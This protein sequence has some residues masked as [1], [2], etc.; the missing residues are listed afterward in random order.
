MTGN[1]CK[2]AVW[3]AS[4]MRRKGIKMNNPKRATDEVIKYVYGYSHSHLKGKS[5]KTEL[6][7]SRQVGMTLMLMTGVTS[8]QAGKHYDKDHSTA[9]HSRNVII[10]YLE[11]RHPLQV[12][13]SI[14]Q[15][16]WAMKYF[17]PHTDLSILPE[18]WNHENK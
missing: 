4:E 13:E 9:L 18:N 6:V 11:T 5:R 17:N 15:A 14:R 1:L 10:N 2:E 12:C 16:I 8:T 3:I 7:I